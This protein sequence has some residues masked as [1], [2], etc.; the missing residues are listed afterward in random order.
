MA[1]IRTRSVAAG[2]VAGAIAATVSACGVAPTGDGGDG[3]ITLWTHN[4][5]NDAELNIIK[6]IVKDYNASQDDYTVTIQAFP[7]QAYNS[8]V[9]SGAVS[10]KLPCILDADAPT[11]PS[12]AYSGFLAPLDISQETLDKQLPSTLGQYDGDVY[13]VGYYDVALA[14]FA[15]KDA[16][17]AAGVRVATLDKPWTG[18]E[19]DKALSAIKKLDDY[20]YPLDLGTGDSGTEWWS[21]AYGPFL[22]SFG[23]DFIDRETYKTAEGVLNGE[24][25]LAWAEW[26]RGLVEN[27]YMPARSNTDAFAD[28]VNGR[29]AM[30]WSG[31]WSNAV[32]TEQ[33]DDGVVMPPPDFGNGPRI[34][35]GSWQWAVSSSCVS[36]DAAIDYLEFSLKPEY[37]SRFAEELGLVPATRE[38]AAITPGWEPGSPNEFF[39]EASERFATIRPPTPGYPYL[40]ST[41][42]K[43]AQ[44]IVAGGDR[45]K[46]L[47]QAVE[48]IAADLKSNQYYG[49]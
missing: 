17:D 25:A 47:D 8:A 39:L 38:A 11:V 12:W 14:L 45:K 5:G 21:Y 19:F 40:T 13:S 41:F 46:L 29:S 34:G 7:Q 10:K 37:L 3:V 15:H 24:Q 35:G 4:A 18:E 44:D 49:Y 1:R 36:K 43:A 2:I 48:D 27:G 42:A 6:D 32:F 20:E 26:F 33:V 9:V 16:L 22:W 28:F 23:G 30:V 31:S